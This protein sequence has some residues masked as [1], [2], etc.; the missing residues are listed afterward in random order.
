MEKPMKTAQ[1]ILIH[2]LAIAA[3]CTLLAASCTGRTQP[4]AWEKG[5]TYELVLLHTN[6]HHGAILPAGGRGGLVE[7]AAYIQAARDANP[8]VLLLDAGD[9]NTGPA[10]SNMF[11]AEPDILAYNLL[12]YDAAV[13]G[14][15]EFDGSR[16]KLE[17]QIEL[18]EFPFVSSNIKDKDGKFLGGNQYIIKDYDGFRVGIF[19]ITTL[20]TVS[21]A[22]SGS[23][24]MNSLEFINEITAARA[25]VEILR[26][27]EKANIIIGL[28]H[29][30]DVKE[31]ADHVTSHELAA[32]VPGIDIIVDGHSHT[33]Q[34]APFNAGGTW[35]VSANEWGKYIGKG[36]LSVLNGKL[37]GF[38]WQPVEIKNGSNAEMS[39]LITPY[40]EKADESLNEVIGEASDEFIFGN[41]LPRYG[42]TAIGNM[43]GDATVW[44]LRNKFNQEID[45]AFHNGGNIRAGLPAGPL[46]RERILAVLP[47]ENYLHIAS[48]SGEEL[49]ALFYFIAHIPQGSGGFPQ[50]SQEV[51]Y[52]LNAADASISGLSINGKPIDPLKTYRFSTNDFLMSGGDGYEILTTARD[53]F[54][55]SLLLSYVVI[56]YINAQNKTASP[57]IDGR[58]QV[59]K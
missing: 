52:T 25:A 15:H 12:G 33:K 45:F 38:E 35:I 57:I 55:T 13:F 8:N 49:D 6:D 41:R 16:Q 46:T 17:K 50:F 54:N 18:A 47:F 28:T 53:P 43:I 39:A 36:K 19:G 58:M 3:L 10:L 21:I 32:A 1:K 14:N 29:I 27:K 2:S 44:Y 22:G 24:F 31:S 42:E 30:G 9:I 40:R 23:E 4:A 59:A 26:R 37:A 5:K 56:E 11:N 48:L 7:R 20:R 34:E 51:R